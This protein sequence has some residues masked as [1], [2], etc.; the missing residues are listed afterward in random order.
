MGGRVSAHEDED[1]IDGPFDRAMDA[2]IRD[3]ARARTPK[4]EARP[5]PEPIMVSEWYR[6]GCCYVQHPSMTRRSAEAILDWAERTLPPGEPNKLNPS[7]P[8]AYAFKVLRGGFGDL[9]PDA[10]IK[11]LIAKNIL[12]AC[13]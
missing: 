3:D 5:D 7:L 2:A 11:S 10:G 13:R 8:N 9:A 1:G 6:R 12:R 4:R